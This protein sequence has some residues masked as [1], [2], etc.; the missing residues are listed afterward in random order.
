MFSFNFLLVQIDSYAI[1]TIVMLDPNAIRANLDQLR[2]ERGYS[3]AALSRAIGRNA[4]YIQQFVVRGSPVRL[5]DKD[6]QIIA[7]MLGCDERDLG[8][9]GNGTAGDLDLVHVRRLAVEASAGS[10]LLVDQETSIG[11][12]TF[13][14]RW[15]R[16]LTSATSSDLSIIRVRGDSMAPTLADGDNALVDELQRDPRRDDGVYVL[17]RDDALMI[18]RLTMMPSSGLLTISSDNPAYPSW[19]DCPLSSLDV[20]GRAVGKAGRVR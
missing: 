8:G 2:K 9:S 7:T 18:K 14:R 4:A 6:R 13:S 20:I 5:E 1:P 19:R 15:L 16:Q 11:H 12:F 3:Y 10:G 17:R